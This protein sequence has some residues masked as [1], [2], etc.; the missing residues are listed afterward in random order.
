MCVARLVRLTTADC[1]ND[2]CERTMP[3]YVAFSNPLTRAYMSN[4]LPA[5]VWTRP[6]DSLR[7]SSAF[8]NEFS[9]AATR[10]WYAVVVKRPSFRS[11]RRYSL[12]SVVEWGPLCASEVIQKPCGVSQ[13][14]T[15]VVNTNVVEI[16]GVE[17]VCLSFKQ[18]LVTITSY[19][20]SFFAQ[21]SGL[22]SLTAID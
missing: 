12:T 16:F 8:Y 20:F 10:K 9:A 11:R 18:R 5:Y 4:S 7:C 2:C 15:I 17:I 3:I 21:R 1:A 13:L 14:S 19:S 6:F 22:T